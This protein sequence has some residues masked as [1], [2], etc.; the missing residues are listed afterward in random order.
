M[1][2]FDLSVDEVVALVG[3]HVSLAIDAVV[4]CRPYVYQSRDLLTIPV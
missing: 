2:V 3:H 1:G 4:C